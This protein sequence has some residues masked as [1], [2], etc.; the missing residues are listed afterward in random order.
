MPVASPEIAIAT[1]PDTQSDALDD[2]VPP[3]SA[4]SLE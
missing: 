2:A 1:A 3:S 4:R